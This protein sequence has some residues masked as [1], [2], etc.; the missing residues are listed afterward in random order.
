MKLFQTTRPPTKEP[1]NVFLFSDYSFV[2]LLHPVALFFFPCL[3]FIMFPHSPSFCFLFFL[4]HLFSLFATSANY[5]ASP[6]VKATACHPISPQAP[7]IANPLACLPS[8]LHLVFL[9]ILLP[10]LLP[11][12]PT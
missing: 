1:F 8:I 2:P 5:E 6:P 3:L 10:V 12:V 4:L 11:S 9:P 7:P